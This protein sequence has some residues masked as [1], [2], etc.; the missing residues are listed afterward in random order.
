MPKSP[1]T[2]RHI[3]HSH[4][5]GRRY[6]SIDQTKSHR[7]L[8]TSVIPTDAAGG[9]SRSTKPSC[10]D[11]SPHLSFPRR[12]P[13]V[14]V[15]RPN[16]VASTARPIGHSHRAGSRN[17]FSPGVKKIDTCGNY[18]L[19]THTLLGAIKLNAPRFFH[20]SRNAIQSDNDLRKLFGC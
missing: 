3:C 5:G 4:G 13:A 1:S 6:Q 14:P 20:H 2:A 12:R 15:D 17:R 10:I 16:Q 18:R 7:P 19:T 11:R 8:A 9:T